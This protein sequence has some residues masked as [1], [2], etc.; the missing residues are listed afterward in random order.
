M[1]Y[2]TVLL[3]RASIKGIVVFFLWEILEK[4]FLGGGVVAE[5]GVETGVEVLFIFI[6]E[7]IT[8]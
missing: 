3:V 6:L 5:F 8:Y 7:G 1:V 4:D 2:V